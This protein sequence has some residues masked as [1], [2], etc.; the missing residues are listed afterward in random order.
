MLGTHVGMSSDV[1][2]SELPLDRRMGEDLAPANTTDDDSSRR[3]R[4]S[5][6]T[7]RAFPR[8]RRYRRSTAYALNTNW[9]RRAPISG[10]FDFDDTSSLLTFD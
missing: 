1:T 7:V 6:E 2:Y 8:S 5:M 4:G 10:T 9:S 3:L